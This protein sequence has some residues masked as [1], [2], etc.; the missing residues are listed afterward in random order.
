[1]QDYWLTPLIKVLVGM[2][3]VGKSTLLQ[4]FSTWLCQEKALATHQILLLDLESTSFFAL[5]SPEK[6]LQLILDHQTSY[7][8]LRVILIDEVQEIP[9]WEKVV[10]A[11]HKN[12]ELQIYLTGSNSQMLSSELSTLLSGRF[13]E[14]EVLP[15]SYKEYLE[16]YQQEHSAKSWE[17]FLRYGGLPGL[18]HL[19]HQDHILKQTL[20]SIYHTVLYRDVIERHQVRQ[21]A[22]L[23]RLIHFFFDNIGQLISAK[24]IVDYCKSQKIQVTV[25]TVQNY[26]S[27][28]E[29]CY[30]LHRVGR[31]DLKGKKWL[32]IGEKHYLNDLG[33]RC[34]LM[35]PR[36]AD[37]AQL[38]E[39]VVYLELR[40]RGWKIFIGKWDDLEIDFVA[41]RGDQVEY[42]QVSYLLASPETRQREF[43]PLLKIKDQYP[44]TVLS[45]DPMYQDEQGIH[46]LNLIAWLL[47]QRH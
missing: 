7:P 1:M 25:D 2:R 15:L 43:Q 45:L 42:F 44:K 36:T 46:N 28:L 14:I 22:F 18:W 17:S 5:N 21:P 47:E 41:M 26:R 38:L 19:P 27:Y 24:K 35:G 29:S 20:E 3:R 40:R 34:A 12:G 37:I 11:L 16:L 6:L 30:A 10:N 39:N 13:I 32:E 9:G 8:D 33:I 31:Y 4:Q 23:Q